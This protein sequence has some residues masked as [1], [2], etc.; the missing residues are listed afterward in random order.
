MRNEKTKGSQYM[1]CCEAGKNQD[2]S[3]CKAGKNQDMSCCKAGENQY[4]SW[5]EAKKR[6][7]SY[8]KSANE[9]NNAFIKMLSD[10]SENNE[11]DWDYLVELAR[12]G[13]Y[14]VDVK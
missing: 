14:G 4:M 6:I 8:M 11:L 5:C 10:A 1:S 12:K 9:E 13:Y 7:I 3:C 2:M